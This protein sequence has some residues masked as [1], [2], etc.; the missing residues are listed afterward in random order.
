[1]LLTICGVIVELPVDGGCTAGGILCVRSHAICGGGFSTTS[2]A[3][4]LDNEAAGRRWWRVLCAE[5]VGWGAVPCAESVHEE[6]VVFVS[7]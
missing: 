1:M 6:G 2:A 3:A 5:R 4:A 7:L